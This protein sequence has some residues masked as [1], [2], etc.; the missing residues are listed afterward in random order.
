MDM[1]INEH[2]RLE[3]ENYTLS[4]K[5]PNAKA[6]DSMENAYGDSSDE[7]KEALISSF[8]QI[9]KIKAMLESGQ[10]TI[11]DLPEDVREVFGG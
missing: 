9:K 10:L 11:D 8:E 3:A 5:Y 6:I 4:F 1:L 2:A 7:Q